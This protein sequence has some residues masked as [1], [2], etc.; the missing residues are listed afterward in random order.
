MRRRD[1]ALVQEAEGTSQTEGLDSKYEGNSSAAQLGINPQ[2]RRTAWLPMQHLLKRRQNSE[3]PQ[4]TQ[5]AA[6]H[7][8]VNFLSAY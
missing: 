8:T 2:D 6:N 5:G 7:P 4:Q 3:V 1:G